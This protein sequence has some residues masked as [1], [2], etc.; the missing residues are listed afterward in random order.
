MA[1]LCRDV[2]EA[3][4]EELSWQVELNLWYEFKV[5]ILWLVNAWN[6]IEARSKEWTIKNKKVL[7]SIL[8]GN[9]DCGHFVNTK[10]L[11]TN[12]FRWI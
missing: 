10:L 3:V 7:L 8:L 1:T 5:H 11:Y 9:I 6:V 2:G 4:S 12:T